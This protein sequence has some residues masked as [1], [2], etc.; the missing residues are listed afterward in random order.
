MHPIG[1]QARWMHTSG[2][3]LDICT[4]LATNYAKGG[5]REL[6]LIPNL[7]LLMHTHGAYQEA[8]RCARFMDTYPPTK[9]APLLIIFAR[10]LSGERLRAW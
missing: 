5:H 10:G 8:V 1:E 2:K 4:T 3:A 9:M 7:L 6:H